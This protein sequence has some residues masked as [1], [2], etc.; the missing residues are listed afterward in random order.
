MTIEEKLITVIID[1]PEQ[2]EIDVLN[3][4]EIL[5]TIPSEDIGKMIHAVEL[6]KNNC[7]QNKLRKIQK[8]FTQR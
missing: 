7:S 3:Q 2:S 1:F 6:L 8:G 4:S 5:A